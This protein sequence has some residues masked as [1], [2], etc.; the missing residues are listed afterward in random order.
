MACALVADPGLLAGRLAAIIPA[1]QLPLRPEITPGWGVAGVVMLATGAVYAL[2]GI[3]NRWI[4]TFLSTAFIT[5]LGVA[6][7]IVYVMT[8]PVTNAVQGGFVVAVILSGCAVGAASMFFKELTEGLGCALGGFCVS[9]WLLCLVPGG[10]LRPVPSKAIFIACFTLA[11]FAF[12]FSRLT[13]DWALIA[14]ISFAGA[15]ITV[16]GIDCFSRAGLKEFWAYVWDIN[17][18]LFPLGATTYPVTKGIRVETAAIFI[19]F[20]V[21]VVSQ[22]KLWRIVRDKRE[23]RAAERAEGQRNLQ[24]EEEDVGRQVEEFNARERRQWERACGDGT[25]TSADSRMSD[26]GDTGSEKRLR[27]SRNGSSKPHSSAEAFELAGIASESDKSRSSPVGLLETEGACD[28]KVTVRVAAEDIPASSTDESDDMDEKVAAAAAAAAAAMSEHRRRSRPPATPASR[29]AEQAHAVT[30]PPRVVPLPFT[31]PGADDAKSTNDDRSS[32]ATFADEADGEVLPQ[33]RSKRP[34]LVKRLSQGSATLLRSLSHRSGGGGAAA[35][36]DDAASHDDGESAAG[37]VVPESPQR[38]A[39]NE[40]L[41]ATVDDESLSGADRRSSLGGEGAHARK[42]IEINAELS[43]DSEAPPPAAPRRPPS[44]VVASPPTPPDHH[45][46]RTPQHPGSPAGLSPPSSPLEA[47]SEAPGAGQRSVAASVSTAPASLTQERLPRPLSRVAMSYRT[48]EWAKH[49]SYAETPEPEDVRVDQQPAQP[50]A[51][52]RSVP[53]DVDELQ[54]TAEA[55]VPAPATM[56]RSESLAS[57]T[58]HVAGSGARRAAAAAAAAHHHHAAHELERARSSGSPPASSPPQAATAPMGLS[59]SVSSAVL[60]RASSGFKPIAEEQGPAAEAMAERGPSPK[61]SSRTPS[62]AGGEAPT[63]AAVPGLVSYASPQTLIGQR[64]LFLRNR[65]QG[66]LLSTTPE[67]P[68][69][70]HGP[71]SDAGSLYNYPAY[72]AALNVADPDDMPLSQRKEIMRQGSL[73]SLSQP[74]TSYTRLSSAGHDSADSLQFNSHQ[75]KRVS[76]LPTQAA[77]DSKLA[78]FRLS[79]QHDLRA[80]TPV[81]ATSTRE[82][83]FAPSSLLG[84]R[85][86]EVQRNI[87]MQRNVLMGQKEAEAQRRELQRRERELTDRAFEERMR[88]GEFLDA[89]RE[90]MRKMQRGAR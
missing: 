34:S 39:D 14:M 22:I 47:L 5:A 29:R 70:A 33:P 49:L 83:P 64:E 16:L 6:V 32:I 42:S 44:I 7:L 48:N 13:R 46:A 12:Y 53:V 51:G 74:S 27:I 85:E 36:A 61:P 17:G 21:G 35:A 2:V 55:G 25:V 73:M 88:N 10:L 4:H 3:K 76:A 68:A 79:V 23:R 8:L 19:I 65:S 69:T 38:D 71:G 86:A 60:H 89:H 82:T 43:G 40:S 58:G 37:L 54:K 62:L 57:S 81:M 72:A 59:R 67:P 18:N 20:L 11:A 31:I 41:A 30:E 26:L 77:R 15:T 90:A 63:R 56:R 75:P 66:S 28:G 24:A 80:G 45:A 84:N 52:E 87:E 1:G 78:N 50:V 9:M